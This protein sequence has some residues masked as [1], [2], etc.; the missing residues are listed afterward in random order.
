MSTAPGRCRRPCAGHSPPGVAPHPTVVQDDG[1]IETELEAT[2]ALAQCREATWI[3][4]RAVGDRDEQVPE[5]SSREIEPVDQPCDLES[6]GLALVRVVPVL[7]RPL[8]AG[9]VPGGRAQ[10]A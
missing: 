10:K 8:A 4:L 1:K 3:A 7:A 5:G 6:R 2:L 9:R